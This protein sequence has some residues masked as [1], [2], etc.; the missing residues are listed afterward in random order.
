MTG[1]GQI[2]AS[3][4]PLSE[5]VEFT[6]LF[7]QYY[8]RVRCYAE[9]CFR[10]GDADEIAQETM[11]RALRQPLAHDGS[12]D[13]WPWLMVTARN[14][15]RDSH[16]RSQRIGW[17]SDEILTR[18]ECLEA[19][20]A[21]DRILDD[22]RRLALK[23]AVGELTP[24]QQRVFLMHV[25]EDMSCAEIARE[26]G[27]TPAGVRQML[28]RARR[29]LAFECRAMHLALTWPLI[30]CLG[31]VKSLWRQRRS[32]SSTVTKGATA[33]GNTFALQVAVSATLFLG[34]AIA[35]SAQSASPGVS[36]PRPPS[37]HEVSASSSIE[38]PPAA[39]ARR[40]KPTLAAHTP[41]LRTTIR[42]P[43]P[44]DLTRPDPSHDAVMILDTPLGPITVEMHGRRT[45]GDGVICTS[46]V[47]R[48]EPS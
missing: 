13:V 8:T 6:D 15:G 9:K 39:P 24:S 43:R 36:G 14:I 40:A 20:F 4:P 27:Q 16:R 33:S 42:L 25:F 28:V 38:A 22:D 1:H 29:R 2:R 5:E 44:R 48:C 12:R 7:R 26:L 32:S 17:V 11:L 31:G 19:T 37:R 30:P 35:S 3:A 18:R 21:F 23:R 47:V 10:H 41:P 45:P 34:L 46:G